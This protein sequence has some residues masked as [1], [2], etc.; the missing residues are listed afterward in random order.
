MIANSG[1]LIHRLKAKTHRSGYFFVLA[2]SL[3]RTVI[4]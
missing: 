1:D 2:H 4:P 3:W